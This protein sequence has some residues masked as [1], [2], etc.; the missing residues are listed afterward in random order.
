MSV[1]RRDTVRVRLPRPDLQV[2]GIAEWRFTS[3]GDVV[4]VVA[5][6]DGGDVVIYVR[7]DR[8]P[9]AEAS[10]FLSPSVGRLVAAALL[11]AARHADGQ[12]RGRTRGG[13]GT[14]AS[15]VDSGMPSPAAS[16]A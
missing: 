5:H 11:A 8:S 2:G 14:S 16:R 3:V 6:P 1:R 9:L 7:E 15:N 10:A 13:S 12:G 4:V